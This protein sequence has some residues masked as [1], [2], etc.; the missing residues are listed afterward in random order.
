MTRAVVDTSII[1]KFE[2]VRI[3]TPGVFLRV[4]E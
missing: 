2:T 4:L 3:V 1:K